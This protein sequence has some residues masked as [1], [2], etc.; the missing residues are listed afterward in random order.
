MIKIAREPSTVLVRGLYGLFAFHQPLISY[1][2]TP[3]NL[4][5]KGHKLGN[6]WV[7]YLSL[8]CH[9]MKCPVLSQ[10]TEN[11][12]DVKMLLLMN[13][14][15]KR[16]QFFPFWQRHSNLQENRFTNDLDND[17]V[18]VGLKLTIDTK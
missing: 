8:G 4:Q 2:L 5:F 1:P 15:K 7:V 17:N 18:C 10:T 3:K 11:V 9:K 12:F 13:L 14:S 6:N 16:Q